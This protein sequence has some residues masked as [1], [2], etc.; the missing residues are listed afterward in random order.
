MRDFS[1]NSYYAIYPILSSAV[2]Y[3]TIY[4]F[5]Q[6][7]ARGCICLNCIVQDSVLK[8]DVFRWQLMVVIGRNK[9]GSWTCFFFSI[10]GTF[11]G[12][13]K[14]AFTEQFQPLSTENKTFF[15]KLNQ[16]V[17]PPRFIFPPLARGET[18]LYLAGH[19][20]S[21]TS[22]FKSFSKIKGL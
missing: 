8:M 21:L 6:S 3:I 16:P 22:S 19:V 11:S 13:G 14:I 17:F 20:T 12:S 10:Q 4:E 9:R 7:E 15:T 2:R 5:F 1:S 18:Q